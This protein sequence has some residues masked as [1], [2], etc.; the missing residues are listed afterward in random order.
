MEGYDALAVAI[1]SALKKFA[2]LHTIRVAPTLAEAETAA[3]EMNPELFVLDLDPAPAGDVDFMAKLQS[4]CPEARM[5]VIAAGTSR[6]LRA[7]RGTAS[8]VQFIEKPFDLGEFGAAVQALLGPWATPPSDSSR[9][10]LRDLHVVDVM[11]LKC[12]ALSTAMVKLESSGGRT[13]EI[14]FQHGQIT[15]AATQHASGMK[16]L[17][18]IVRWPGGR[19]SEHKL[20]EDAP[21]TVG[22]QPWPAVL[23]HIV[24]KA[25]EHAPRKPPPAAPPPA[26]KPPRK[27]ILA[28]DDTEMLLIFAADVLG[29]AHS[30][31]EIVTALTGA[32]GIKL[33]ASLQP[34]LILLD[35]SLTDMTGAD[36]CRQ[37]LLNDRSARIPVLMMSG[38]LPELAHTAA[39]FG[40]VVATLPKP[41]LSGALIEAVDKLLD[42]G[43]LPEKPQPPEPPPAESAP[44]Q[45]APPAA[46]APSAQPE[47]VPL[48]RPSAPNG[49][50][51]GHGPTKN[52]GPASTSAVLATPAVETER[53][54][55][56]AV[57]VA[58][59]ATEE[60]SAKEVMLTFPL[61]IVA[62]QLRP[63]LHMDSMHLKPLDAPASVRVPD[64]GEIGFLV[65]TSFRMGQ[66]QLTPEGF[67]DT[68]ILFPTANAPRLAPGSNAF[69]VQ[70]VRTEGSPKERVVEL[71]AA[72]ES[73]AMRVHL[74]ARFDF[75]TVELSPTFEVVAVILRARG[76]DVLIG[77]GAASTIAPFGIDQAQVDE[78]GRIREL[79]VS[80]PR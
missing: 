56:P 73:E 57:G 5:L 14:H 8:A 51:N 66:A 3:A 23:L 22:D 67:I 80:S 6:E 24:R 68:L 46:S 9:G 63:D 1:A 58:P 36:V 41:F 65:E 77:P 18:D 32:E 43:P 79:F 59:V 53:S 54:R 44:K 28:I 17:E 19:I 31:F 42:A 55:F 11:Q 45:A 10:T 37:L 26:P 16:A 47:S 27:K 49:H 62:M 72:T 52:S 64:N 78:S 7:E 71:T 48:P 25:A 20:P 30:N 29:T 21:K 35:Y 33:A 50:G 2:P 40:N 76:R 61:T 69:A 13:G 34:D 38:H 70:A 74:A 4:L 39:T 60:A 15:H 12:L 75:L